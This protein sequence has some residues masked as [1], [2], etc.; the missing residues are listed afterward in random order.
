MSPFLQI[1]F[2]PSCAIFDRFR[3]STSTTTDTR[4][5]APPEAG[6]R[7]ENRATFASG[8]GKGVERAKA[9][10]HRRAEGCERNLWDVSWET[11]AACTYQ[12]ARR[13]P[14]FPYARRAPESSTGIGFF[15]RKTRTHVVKWI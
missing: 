15:N 10:G 4:E 9:P 2:L 1:G 6:H 11:P 7:E 12:A 3:S 14:S 8:T 13:P 5:K